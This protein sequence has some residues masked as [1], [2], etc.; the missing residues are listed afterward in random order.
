M[1]S[2]MPATLASASIWPPA[3]AT[4]AATRGVVGDVRRPP[5]RCRRRRARPRSRRGAPGEMSTAITRPPSRATLDAV[6]R[7]MPEPAPVTITVWPVNRPGSMR[8]THS[9]RSTGAGPDAAGCGWRRGVRR[10]RCAGGH[11]NVAGRGP[12]HEVV[13]QL[14][15]NAPL[16]SLT[17]RLSA[18]RRTGLKHVGALAGLGEQVAQDRAAGGVVEPGADRGVGGERVVCAMEW[19]LFCTGQ[20]VRYVGYT[21]DLTNDSESAG[22][23][24]EPRAR[25]PARRTARR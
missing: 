19:F 10:I 6:A 22:H 4:I 9:G 18:S 16:L 21:R 13:D 14:G 17:R 5:A 15:R 1:S 20:V 12:A 24:G 11:R 8:S 23:E 7:P 3:A 25:A 2:M